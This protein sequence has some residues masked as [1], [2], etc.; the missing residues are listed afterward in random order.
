VN[1][2]KVNLFNED[3][4]FELLKT[5]ETNDPGRNTFCCRR[6][7]PGSRTPGAI[8]T[9]RNFPPPGFMIQKNKT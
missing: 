7:N 4:C 2:H 9:L 1:T 6:S 5:N 8:F 3:K